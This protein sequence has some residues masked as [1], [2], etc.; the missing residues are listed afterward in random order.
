MNEPRRKNVVRMTRHDRCGG[1]VVTRAVMDDV[2]VGHAGWVPCRLTSS[3]Q[4]CRARPGLALVAT[5]LNGRGWQ[6][7]GVSTREDPPSTTRSPLCCGASVRQQEAEPATVPHPFL[8]SPVES[9]TDRAEVPKAAGLPPRE[10]PER[11]PT[12]PRPPQ[13]L[14]PPGYGRGSKP[15]S[16]ARSPAVAAGWTSEDHSTDGRESGEQR[17][18]RD[19]V[20]E[21]AP[22]Q[23]VLPTIPP[24][25]RGLGPSVDQTTA[26]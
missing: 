6:P 8:L 21:A 9:R 18:A 22:G 23:R 16:P 5:H 12:E 26:P 14:F 7:A 1:L 20:K 19:A 17:R 24:P 10:R 3:T 15:S 2:G 13:P 25:L 4:C 11:L